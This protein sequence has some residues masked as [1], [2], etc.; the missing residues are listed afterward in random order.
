[1]CVTIPD[2]EVHRIRSEHVGDDFEVWIARPQAGFVP[3]Q[4]RPAVLYVLDANLFFGTVVEMTRVMHRLYGELPQLLVVGIAYP[5]SDWARQGALR[6][7]DFT[8]S[9]DPG[10]ADMAAKMPP[11][12]GSEPVEP[13]MGGADAFRRFLVGEV[14]PM[15]RERYD[16]SHT[17]RTIVGSSMGGL[18]VTWALLHHPETFDNYLAVSP[19]LWWNEAELVDAEAPPVLPAAYFAAGGNE[20]SHEVPMLARFR[21]ISNARQ[22]ASRL[23]APIEVL[24]GESHTSVVPVALTRGLRHFFPRRPPRVE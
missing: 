16:P 12:P 7:R 3:A 2:T 24:E 6:A 10:M 1:M 23:G 11:M 9:E 17:D 8:P 20:E 14:D 5:G 19:A 13:A 21:M 4:G 15:I 22:L 18:F